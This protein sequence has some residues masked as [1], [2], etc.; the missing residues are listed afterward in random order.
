MTVPIL[1]AV[2][3]LVPLVIAGVALIVVLVRR[4]VSVL[5]RRRDRRDRRGDCTCSSFPGRVR[6]SVRYARGET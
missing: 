1:I 6:G 3:I 5:L 2:T 4:R